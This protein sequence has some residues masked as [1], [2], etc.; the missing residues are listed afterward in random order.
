MEPWDQ[1]FLK[2]PDDSSAQPE[3]RTMAVEK[4]DFDIRKKIALWILPIFWDMEVM[5]S[6][7]LL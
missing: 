4:G 2:L 6:A 5:K 7:L 1:Y 3:F